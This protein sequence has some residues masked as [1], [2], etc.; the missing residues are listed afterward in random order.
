[1]DLLRTKAKAERRRSTRFW[2]S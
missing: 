2:W 1:V